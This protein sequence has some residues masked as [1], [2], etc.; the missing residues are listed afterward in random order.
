MRDFDYRWPFKGRDIPSVYV[1]FGA[2]LYWR[3]VNRES[4]RSFGT[5][6]TGMESMYFMVRAARWRAVCVDWIVGQ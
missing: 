4:G 1:C 5:N 3:W 6:M 2:L